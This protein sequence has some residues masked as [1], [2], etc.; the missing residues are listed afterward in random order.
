VPAPAKRGLVQI[1]A[2]AG[3][4]VGQQFYVDIKAGDVQN[5]AGASFI[6]SY[7]PALVD[8]VSATEGGFLKKDG[9]L[10]TFSAV[11]SAEEGTLTINLTRTPNSGGMTGAGTLVSALFREKAKGAAS[12]GFQSLNFTTADGKP[13]EMLPFSTA[14]T[15]R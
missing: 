5:L 12:F 10:T 2:P 7:D 14:V 9:K 13:H 15:V 4:D 11:G 3:I 8:Y 6:L 1:A